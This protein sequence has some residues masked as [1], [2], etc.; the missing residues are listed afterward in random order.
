[1]ERW[2]DKRLRRKEAMRNTS[3]VVLFKLLGIQTGTV[4]VIVLLVLWNF[5]LAMIASVPLLILA[6]RLGDQELGI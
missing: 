6:R 1:M 2:R 3:T 5:W 4:A